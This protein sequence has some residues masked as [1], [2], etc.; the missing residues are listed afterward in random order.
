MLLEVEVDCERRQSETLDGRAEEHTFGHSISEEGVEYPGIGSED[1]FPYG[2][3]FG[4]PIV[5]LDLLPPALEQDHRIWPTDN[6]HRLSLLL[7]HK[8]S[9]YSASP[10]GCA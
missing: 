5:R 9:S 1:W 7:R 4:L 6:S 3:T 8:N 10:A 2:M